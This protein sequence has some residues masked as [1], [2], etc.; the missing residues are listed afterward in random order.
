MCWSGWNRGWGEIRGGE[1]GFIDV[2][3]EGKRQVRVYGNDRRKNK[4][5]SEANGF[6]LIF[7]Q[8]VS[9]MCLNGWERVL[10][11]MEMSVSRN[12]RRLAKIGKR[13]E[14]RWEKRVVD[15]GRAYPEGLDDILI[16]I[17][18]DWRNTGDF[19]ITLDK[20]SFYLIP[21][22]HTMIDVL[23]VSLLTTHFN[24]WSIAEI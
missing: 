9:A 21:P 12:G 1:L 5:N 16:H 10:T 15:D 18:T 8:F 6:W 11:E 24:A 19:S 3:D 23:L 17:K 4:G 13:C 2:V 14:W 22:A 20:V 7:L